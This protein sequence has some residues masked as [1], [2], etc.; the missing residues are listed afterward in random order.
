MGGHQLEEKIGTQTEYHTGHSLILAELVRLHV[1]FVCP[2]SL[3]C[4][5]FLFPTFRC[6]LA[7]VL[8][9]AATEEV[10]SPFGLS[11]VGF[12]QVKSTDKLLS[13]SG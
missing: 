6:A 1:G 4:E 5:H 11:Q 12:G 10:G 7:E 3:H 9:A 13:Q 8:L 2:T